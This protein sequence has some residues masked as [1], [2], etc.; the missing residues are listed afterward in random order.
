[1]ERPRSAIATQSR[2]AGPRG[3]AAWALLVLSWIGGCQSLST[4]QQISHLQAENERLLSDYRAAQRE[5]QRLEQ[6][7][8][9]LAARL[10]DPQRSIVGNT[11]PAAPRLGERP[12]APSSSGASSRPMAA[13]IEPPDGDLN[14]GWKP[15][16]RR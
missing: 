15:S 11:A 16:G 10:N 6:E 8:R 12:F 4:K 13:N 2:L 7:N 1:M 5:Q 14:D 9:R 3:S